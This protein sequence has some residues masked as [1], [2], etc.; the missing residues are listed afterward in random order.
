MAVSS[1]ACLNIIT[2]A[3]DA[4]EPSVYRW[5]IPYHHVAL[6]CQ[7][8]LTVASVTTVHSLVYLH[9]MVCAYSATLI[10]FTVL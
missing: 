7:D 9:C 8:S 5:K 2:Y 3:P 1:L 10:V 6:H 4:T